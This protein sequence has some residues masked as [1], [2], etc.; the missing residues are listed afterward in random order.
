MTH[1]RSSRPR[2]ALNG[3]LSAALLLG[4]SALLPGCPPSDDYFIDTST[5]AAGGSDATGGMGGAGGSATAALGG[6]GGADAPSVGGSGQAEAGSGG[7]AAL[8]GASGSG[9]EPATT[10]WTATS[11]PPG[12]FSPRER[13]SFVSIGNQLFVWGGRNESGTALSSGAL[14]DPRSDTWRT[15]A[16]DANTPSPRCDATAVWTGNVVVVWGGSEPG[17]GGALSDGAIYDP[18]E[19]AWRAMADGRTARVAPIG[20]GAEGRAFFWGG[21]SGDGAQLQGLDVYDIPND[22]WI[23][24]GRGEPPAREEPA[25]AVG[26]YT[27]WAYGGRVDGDKGSDRGAYYSMGQNQWFALPPS[28][29]KPRWGSFGAFVG[30]AFY[31][32]GGRDVGTTFDDGVVLSLSNLMDWNALEDSD[33]PS[34]RYAAAGES[35]WVFPI[36][37]ESFVVV[38]GLDAPGSYLRDGA[39]YDVREHTWAALEAWP[40]SASHAFG[41]AGWVGGELVVWGGR[42]GSSLTNTGVRY[43]LSN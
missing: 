14:Y 13:A 43:R 17:A 8:G 38:G 30:T 29:T 36:E 24:G 34:P 42:D 32:W 1:A 4:V 28:G 11:V 26:M 20:G 23:P 5:P 15:I 21:R 10:G 33:A 7:S 22:I 12:G 37:D 41:A 2:R 6:E 18:V 31:A 35:G 3:A 40:G 39:F 9:G 25:W 27:F 19:D 16:N